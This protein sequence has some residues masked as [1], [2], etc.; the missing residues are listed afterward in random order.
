MTHY[1]ISDLHLQTSHP[2]MTEG[3]LQL[4]TRLQG[5]ESLY[6][7]GDFFEVWIG[8]DYDDPMVSSIKSGLKQLS[9]SGTSVYLMHGNRDFLL[10]NTFAEQAGATL[11]DEGTVIT[12]GNQQALLMHGDSLCTLD[13][14]YMQMRAMFRNPEWQAQIR[15]CRRDRQT[16][17][18]IH[19][20]KDTFRQG[21]NATFT[22]YPVYRR[23][24]QGRGDRA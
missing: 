14:A 6:I 10:G 1:F 18:Q 12:I 19:L 15:N 13:T 23:H 7:L 22:A 20:K 4:L 5:A 8:D 24:Q 9:E 3:F 11:M 17:P 2:K 16:R 21:W